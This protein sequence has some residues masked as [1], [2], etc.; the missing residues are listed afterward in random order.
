ML[1]KKQLSLLQFLNS[2]AKLHSTSPSFDEMKDAMGLKSK[3]GIHR[4][5]AALEERGYIRRL[6]NRARA[7]EVIKMPEAIEET[8]WMGMEAERANQSVV[9]NAVALPVLGKIA[10]GT[11]I[12]AIRDTQNFIDIPANMLPKGKA[13]ALEVQGDSMI[14]V[15]IL[16]GDTA[17]IQSSD[18]AYDGDIIVALIDQEEVTLKK[19]LRDYDKVILQA[20]NPA[21]QDRI[22]SSDRVQVQG[23]LRGLLRQY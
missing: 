7:L 3:S 13:Y 11:A 17:I 23:V 20:A 19:M 2:Y 8:S 15:G 12:E 9:D 22:L 6:P 21:Y 1:T 10:A 16:D 5:I 18:T 14:G 4:L